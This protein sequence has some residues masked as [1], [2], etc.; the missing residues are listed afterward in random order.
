MSN[1]L[2]PRLEEEEELRSLKE[3]GV[4]RVYVRK[5][6]TKARPPISLSWAPINITQGENTID[7]IL[8]L[9]FILF[10]KMI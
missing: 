7:Y 4:N 1:R 9:N 5:T 6:S 8:A 2:W 3:A 10:S